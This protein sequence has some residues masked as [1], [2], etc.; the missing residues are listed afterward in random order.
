MAAQ[1]LRCLA[2]GQPAGAQ[3]RRCRGDRES[4]IATA[5]GPQLLGESASC[6]RLCLPSGAE[7][8]WRLCIY[9]VLFSY[10]FPPPLLQNELLTYSE[11]APGGDRSTGHPRYGLAA[12]YLSC[13]ALEKYFP[14]C[15][16]CVGFFRFYVPP[17]PSDPP[18][19]ALCRRTDE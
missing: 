18:A 4:C 6:T 16:H 1:G 15:H 14:Q 17:A 2:R 19:T 12:S 5:G 9:L 3:P 8:L 10:F 11:P 7:G 13:G